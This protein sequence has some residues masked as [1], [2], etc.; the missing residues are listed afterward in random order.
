MIPKAEML[1]HTASFIWLPSAEISP[2][3]NDVTCT[4]DQNKSAQTADLNHL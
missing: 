1:V 4:N 2:T 3:Y